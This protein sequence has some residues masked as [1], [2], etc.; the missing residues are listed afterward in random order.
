MEYFHYV[1]IMHT[2]TRSVNI[3]YIEFT[4]QYLCRA[5]EVIQR[6]AQ[7]EIYSVYLNKSLD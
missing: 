6:Q 3:A 2:H 1:Y 7:T 5:K 4:V